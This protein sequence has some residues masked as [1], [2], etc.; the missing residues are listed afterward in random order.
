MNKNFHLSVL[1]FILAFT[2]QNTFSQAYKK[3]TLMIGISEGSTKANYTTSDIHTNQ[4]VKHKCGDGVRDPFVI[5]YGISNKWS[6]GLCAGNDIFKVNVADFY[7]GPTLTNQAK[8]TTS[9]FTFDAN[10]H[11]FVNKRLDLSAFTSLGGFSIKIAS[12]ESDIYYKHVA[13][14][15]IIRIGIRARYYFWNRLGAFGMISNYAAKCSPKDVKGNSFGQ[16]YSTSI[17]G[18][19]IETGLCFKIIK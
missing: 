18:F 4:L 12:N 15:N 13:N 10:Y 1:V 7:G 2:A 16:N 9:E 14:G 19:A 5:E 11:F 17:S 6:L 8:V 3:G